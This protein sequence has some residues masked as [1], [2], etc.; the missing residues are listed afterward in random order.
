MASKVP[1]WDPTVCVCGAKLPPERRGLW[2]V[3]CAEIIP[4]EPL[5]HEDADGT[6][7][8][9]WRDDRTATLVSREFL[10]HMV[11]AH[12]AVNKGTVSNPAWCRGYDDGVAIGLGTGEGRERAAIVAWLREAQGSIRW[13]DED[14]IRI[15]RWDGNEF[16]DRIESAAHLRGDDE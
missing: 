12:N 10:D 2:C 3:D 7:T 11:Q 6:V 1:A 5:L 13:P 16:A 8:L 14:G 9:E 15:T 4:T